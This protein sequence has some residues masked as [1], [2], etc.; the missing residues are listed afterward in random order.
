MRARALTLALAVLLAAPSAFGDNGTAQV[1]RMFLERTAIAA[2]D[3]ACN[4]FT[5]GERLALKSGLY[6]AEGELLRANYSRERLDDLAN[7]VR[8]HA[9][10]L[11]CDHPSVLQVA[12][13]VRSSY[14]QFAKTNS[15]EYAAANSSWI[16]SRVE[17]DVW[18]AS[19]TDKASDVTIGLRRE[20]EEKPEALALAVAI[21][22][23]KQP[24][25][26]VQLYMR[27]AKKMGDPW[28]PSL[29]GPG[30]KPTPAPRSIS[31]PE[32]AGRVEE[33]ENQAGDYYLIYYFAP[34]A[35]ERLEQ[36]DPREAVQ[37]ELTPSPLKKDRTP[38]Q[39]NFEVGD[40]RAARAFAM[41][42]K[43]PVSTLAAAAAAAEAAAAPKGGH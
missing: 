13:T 14:R 12:G 2:S 10:A 41:I 24:P 27:D 3:K 1:E 33:Y 38:V 11:G 39:I 22:W 36:L 28:L 17:K 40:I 7:E 23:T 35:I 42:P 26:A 9:K 18:A 19:Q 43:P 20:S 34:T 16:A 31:R 5:E 29:F 8:V 15:L 32:W 6:Q 30:A 4:L 25:S 21:P 37:I